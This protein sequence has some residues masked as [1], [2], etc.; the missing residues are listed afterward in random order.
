MEALIGNKARINISDDIYYFDNKDTVKFMELMQNPS[1]GKE[2]TFG[3]VKSDWFSVFEFDPIG[4]VKDDENIDAAELL[5][6]LIENQKL[7]NKL[8]RERG[9]ETLSI[10]GWKF[11]PRY[12]GVDNRLE[13]AFTIKNDSTGDNVI[14]YHTKFLGRTGII[15]ATLVAAPDILDASVADFK[16]MVNEFSFSPGEKYSEYRKG[17]KVAEYGLAALIVGGAAAVATKKGLW[18]AIAVFFAKFFKLAIVVVIAIFAWI[19]SLFNR[20]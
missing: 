2:Y 9:W 18:A 1:S 3:S 15:Q 4:Y 16:K 13:W 19:A 20:R 12:D 8:R 5:E 7:G 6:T 14:N 17:D 10:V 11:T